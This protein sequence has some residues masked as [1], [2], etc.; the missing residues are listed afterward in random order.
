MRRRAV[1]WT[2]SLALA[3]VTA[4]L[5]AWH[6]RAV[7]GGAAREGTGLE[8]L[9]LYGELPDFALTERSGRAVRRA[10]LAGAV[11]IANFIYTRCTDTCPLQTATLARLQPDLL[12]DGRVRIVSLTVDPGHDTPAVLRRY[13]EQYRADPTRWLFLTGD[14]AAIA[15]LAMEGFHLGVVDPGD[16][17]ASAGRLARWLGP[18]PAYASHGAKGLVLHSPRLVLV[19]GRARVRA[20]HQPDDPRSLERLLE[21]VRRVLA[22]QP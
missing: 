16:V 12:G 10:D 17:A 11:W 13:A 2:A 15:R 3:A 9:G 6:S 4:G 19:D 21:N 5:A 14:P 8:T 22:E 20:Y 18:I 7:P 1:L